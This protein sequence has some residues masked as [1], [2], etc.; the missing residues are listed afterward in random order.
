MNTAQ[1][2]SPG[3]IESPQKPNAIM[4]LIK[5]PHCGARNVTEYTYG[6]A[7]DVA[8]PHDPASLDDMQW[9]DYVYL[10]DNPRGPHDE[11]W[12][13]SAGCRRWVAVRRDTLTHEVIATAEPGKLPPR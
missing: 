8:R 10:R 13:H 9:A 6:G 2:R 1:G 11:I 5:C 4:M 7:A 3:R 12:Q